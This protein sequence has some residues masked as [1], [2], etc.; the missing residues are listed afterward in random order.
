MMGNRTFPGALPQRPDRSHRAAAVYA[1]CTEFHATMKEQVEAY[2]QK[3]GLRPRGLPAMYIKALLLALW[4]GTTYALLY[5]T[6]NGFLGLTLL[7][8]SLGLAMAGIGF[9]IA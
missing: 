9:N 1:A 5:F 6:D 8:I 7:A 4:Y 2:F 3:E